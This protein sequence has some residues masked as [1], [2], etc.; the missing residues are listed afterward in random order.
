[1]LEWPDSTL[2]EGIASVAADRPD[3]PALYFRGERTSYRELLDRAEALAGGLADLGVGPG[4]RIAVWLGNRPSWVVSQLAASYLGAAVVAVNT[5]YRTHELAYMLEDS[6][7]SVLV[8]EESFLGNDYL[9]MLA[10]VVPGIREADPG[11]FDPDSVGSLR[12]VIALDTHEAYPAVRGY[13]A[14]LDR[15]RT[16]DADV[17]RATDPSAPAAVFYTSGTTSDPKGCLQSNR[18]L[19]NH[20]YHAADY[21][22]LGEGDVTLAVLPFCGVWGYNTFMGTLTKGLPLVVQTHFDADRSLELIDDRGVTHFNAQALMLRRLLD[23]DGFTPE[24]VASLRRGVTA[25]LTMSY[26]PEV[27][28]ELEG[29][30]GFPLVQPYGISEGNSMIFVGDPED[31]I[32]RR[33][34]IGGP[35]VHPEAEVRIADPD[36]GEPLPPGEEGEICLRGYN[37]IEAYHD[38]PEKTEETIDDEGWLH[39]GD[40][41]AHDERGYF[42]YRSRLDD[43]LRV[44]GFLVT[45]RDIETVINDHPG[46]ADTQVVG[47]PHPEHGQVPVAFLKRADPDL[48][49]A[50]VRAFL[51]GE[52]AGYKIPEAVEFVDAFPRTEGPHGA[53]VQKTALRERVADRFRDG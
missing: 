25:F 51:D 20:S 38:K 21:L 1:M 48:T 30:L 34:R 52:V 41:G 39:T 8:T 50:D 3:G 33:T 45:P 37:V 10:D 23:A 27:F 17:E 24:R 53:K 4:D 49:A 28:A 6:A 35:P 31:P 44:R 26:D 11:T 42:Y 7:C 13:E 2:Y 15:G 36:S 12:E 47:A 14:V 46:V 32:E 29:T 16:R 40:L 43:A 9:E 18:S 22:G 19:L 5:R